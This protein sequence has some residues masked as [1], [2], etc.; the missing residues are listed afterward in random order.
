[1][2]ARDYYWPRP[3]A[4]FSSRRVSRTHLGAPRPVRAVQDDVHR[5]AGLVG[6]VPDITA[7]SAGSGPVNVSPRVIPQ[8]RQGPIA[9]ML[10]A[11]P[12][13]RLSAG[14]HNAEC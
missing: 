7:S 5:A 14:G 3:A 9:K 10:H 13:H 8:N 6:S 4:A 12:I 2:P 1:M 11:A